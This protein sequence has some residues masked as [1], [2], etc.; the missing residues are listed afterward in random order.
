VHVFLETDRLILR[1][2]TEADVENLV[3]LDSDPQVLRYING[4]TPTPRA[5][6][7]REIL[8]RFLGYYV[9]YDGYGFWAAVERTSDDF[10]GWFCLHPE[11]DDMDRVALGYRLRRA[12][13]EK[14]HAT[15]RTSTESS[16]FPLSPSCHGWRVGP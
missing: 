7:E 3:D 4:G 10:L 9:R 2:F 6:I 8:P 14:G 1:R 12:A 5:V 15:A 13:W 11:D 16:R